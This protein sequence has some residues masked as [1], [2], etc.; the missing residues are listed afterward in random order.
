[1]RVNCRC[2]SA[3]LPLPVSLSLI[4]P[5]F[6]CP[7]VPLHLSPYAL[8]LFIYPYSVSLPP[9]FFY[10]SIPLSLSLNLSFVPISLDPLCNLPSLFLVPSPLVH[11]LSVLFNFSLSTPLYLLYSLPRPPVLH[12][13]PA[14][15]RVLTISPLSLTL[16]CL[17]LS[18]LL[19]LLY[20][21]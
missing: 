17:P 10:V 12:F 20:P 9:S 3:I 18:S 19:P 13:A 4:N 2:C 21:L 6:P 15:S 1:M 7:S 11:P 5:S 8:P 16:L 14:S